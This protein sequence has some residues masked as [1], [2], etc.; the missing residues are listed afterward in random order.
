[1]AGQCAMEASRDVV[2]F[3]LLFEAVRLV[4]IAP[5]NCWRNST[6]NLCMIK[7]ETLGHCTV[8]PISLILINQNMQYLAFPKLNHM[9]RSKLMIHMTSDMSFFWKKYNEYSFYRV[10]SHLKVH[11]GWWSVVRKSKL[12]G[13]CA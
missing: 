9:V 6:P 4:L 12:A 7:L 2:C 11:V 13:V 5:L 8:G 1:M 10:S 3:M